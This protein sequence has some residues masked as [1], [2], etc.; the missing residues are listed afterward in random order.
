MERQL[1]KGCQFTGNL[2]TS[3]ILTVDRC[4]KKN[5]NG[6]GLT[7]VSSLDVNVNDIIDGIPKR[8]GQ[9]KRFIITEI[10]EK[11]ESIYKGKMHY[12]CKVVEEL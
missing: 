8:N 10:S 7:F 1:I 2:P 11:R 12:T 9:D 5:E 3:I 4:N 6:I